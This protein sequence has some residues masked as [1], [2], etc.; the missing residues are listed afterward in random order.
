MPIYL[1]ILDR[2]PSNDTNTKT[3][4][5]KKKCFFIDSVFLIKMCKKKQM[6]SIVLFSEFNKPRPN[7]G[8]G[9]GRGRGDFMN[10][11]ARTLGGGRGVPGRGRGG[12]PVGRSKK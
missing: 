3:I 9:H 7:R 10:D 4:L 1:E 5:K 2:Y 11:L 6:L 8:D 12:P